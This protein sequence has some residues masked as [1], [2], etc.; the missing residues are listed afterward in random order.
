[1]S[2][3]E[4]GMGGQAPA[5]EMGGAPGQ[6]AEM[7]PSTL[8]EN[9]EKII[10]QDDERENGEEGAIEEMPETPNNDDDADEPEEP[11][12][13]PEEQRE[14]LRAQLTEKL[15]ML[16]KAVEQLPDTLGTSG[17]VKDVLLNHVKDQ[18]T[19]L[20]DEQTPAR[21]LAQEE[22]F[23]AESFLLSEESEQLDNMKHENERALRAIKEHPDFLR[24]LTAFNRVNDEI[25]G[26]NALVDQYKALAG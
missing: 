1:M 8:P 15:E 3:F 13:N 25:R 23:S 14:Q 26:Y 2:D 6:N 5:Q 19:D 24:T 12:E 4:S 10:D 16:E 20:D 11:R 9:S 7:E 18:Q 17:Q 22:G 21:I